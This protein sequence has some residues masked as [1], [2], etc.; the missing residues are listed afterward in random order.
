MA[1]RAELDGLAAERQPRCRSVPLTA[2]TS[3]TPPTRA[4]V[5]EVVRGL[6][7]PGAP[8]GGD[9]GAGSRRRKHQGPPPSSPRAR[10]A[11]SRPSVLAGGEPEGT[12]EAS[13]ASR[14]GP[15]SGAPAPYPSTT[16]VSSVGL[17]AA[18][19]LDLVAVLVG[20]EVGHGSESLPRGP[21]PARRLLAA[22]SPCS[23]AFVRCSTTK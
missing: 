23:A 22:C 12:A 21:S 17:R 15:R 9:P 2:A 6:R 16:T 3:P 1:G 14:T 4:F 20:P 8:G 11:A 13:R 19:H 18:D 5:E 10:G 7:P